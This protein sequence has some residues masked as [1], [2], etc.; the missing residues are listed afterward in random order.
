MAPSGTARPVSVELGLEDNNW[1]VVVGDIR[2]GQQVVT[3]GNERLRP[4]SP[5]RV[6][7]STR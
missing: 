6:A 4:G 7:P 1:I 5:V 2:P 3:E